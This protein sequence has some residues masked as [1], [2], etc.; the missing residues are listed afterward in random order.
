MVV[1]IRWWS[2]GCGTRHSGGSSDVVAAVGDDNDGTV[3]VM[4]GAWRRVVVGIE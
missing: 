3:G 4:N 1:V 2:K